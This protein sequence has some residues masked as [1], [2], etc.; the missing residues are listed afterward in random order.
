MLLFETQPQN[1]NLTRGWADLQYEICGIKLATFS[2]TSFPP[3]HSLSLSLFLS[4]TLITTHSRCFS[5][6]GARAPTVGCIW[7]TVQRLVSSSLVQC[8]RHPSIPHGTVARRVRVSS[9]VNWQTATACITYFYILSTTN[10][11]FAFFY[12]LRYTA[13]HLS[14]CRII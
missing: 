11:T 9:F 8:I 13:R 4:H 7:Y 14:S 1:R 2:F 10:P 6:P 3:S 5:R 12:P